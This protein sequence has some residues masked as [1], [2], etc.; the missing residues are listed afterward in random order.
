M[1]RIESLRWPLEGLEKNIR[2]ATAGLEGLGNRYVKDAAVSDG[3]RP[4]PGSLQKDLEE[5]K[6]NIFL[7]DQQ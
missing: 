6:G 4:Q 2:E 5:H 1:Q 3:M 7:P